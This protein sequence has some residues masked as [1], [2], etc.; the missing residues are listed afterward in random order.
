M[1]RAFGG[2]GHTVANRA[3]LTEAL[4][5]AQAADTFTVI[6]C[7]IDRGSYDGRI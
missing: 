3:E 7:T 4:N 1:G 5:A 6:A 2:A